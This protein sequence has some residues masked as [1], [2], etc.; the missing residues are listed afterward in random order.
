MRTLTIDDVKNNGWLILESIAG[1]KSYGLDNEK[2]DTDIRGVFILP[3][4]KYFGL[5]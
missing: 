3:K 1:S 4:R 2:S 5:E